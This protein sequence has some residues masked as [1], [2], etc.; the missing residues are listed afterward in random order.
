MYID[1][2]MYIERKA[3]ERI[4]ED[5]NGRVL[6]E[7]RN[8]AILYNYHLQKPNERSFRERNGGIEIFSVVLF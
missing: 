6:E 8:F 1:C 2:L 4:K 7:E 3:V 5:Q